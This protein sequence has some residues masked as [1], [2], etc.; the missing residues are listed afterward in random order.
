[1]IAEVAPIPIVHVR[2]IVSAVRTLTVGAATT[3][4]RIRRQNED[5]YVA[6]PAAR[7]FAVADG[8]GGIYGGEVASSEACIGLSAAIRSGADLCASI[9]VAHETVK[10]ASKTSTRLADMGT[11][12]VALHVASD[13]ASV[14]IGHVGDSRCYFYKPHDGCF[15]LL[16]RDH[17]IY[18]PNRQRFALTRALGCSDG[19]PDMKERTIDSDCA[20]L[21][22]SDGIHGYVNEDSIVEAFADH[23]DDT[24]SAASI[25]ARLCDMANEA[26]GQD[27]A[28]AVV[29]IV[30]A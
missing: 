7:L 16:T 11:T 4:G 26:G 28:T 20:F 13:L 17:S 14:T 30:R 3:V 5:S 27:N 24:D 8:I 9:L 1:M 25:A 12:L 15:A 29:V 2:P 18:Y 19:R 22:C 10:T 23:W 21:L 6:D